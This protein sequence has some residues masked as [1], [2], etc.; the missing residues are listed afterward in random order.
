MVGELPEGVEIGGLIGEAQRTVESVVLGLENGSVR[1]R[2]WA[3]YLREVVGVLE[4][5]RKE[6]E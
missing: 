2:V 3:E 6:E 1:Q 4:E 5:R